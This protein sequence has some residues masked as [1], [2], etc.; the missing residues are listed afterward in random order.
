MLSP[1]FY[2]E[3]L[4]VTEEV[5]AAG[6]QNS[7]N[8]ATSMVKMFLGMQPEGDWDPEKEGRSLEAVIKLYRPRDMID[9]LRNRA[10]KHQKS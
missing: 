7:G 2:R 6:L 10:H 1:D 5:L 3:S 4:P 9:L 8:G